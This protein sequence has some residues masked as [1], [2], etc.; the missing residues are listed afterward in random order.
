LREPVGEDARASEKFAVEKYNIHAT[1]QLKNISINF[2]LLYY[3][4]LTAPV[5][6]MPFFVISLS[7]NRHPTNPA[8]ELAHPGCYRKGCAAPQTG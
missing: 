7:E 8:I 6:D 5:A 2:N 3:F 1:M 4:S